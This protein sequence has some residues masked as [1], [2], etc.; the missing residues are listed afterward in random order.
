VLLA[1][2]FLF[3]CGGT[4]HSTVLLINA[5]QLLSGHMDNFLHVT[6]GIII[7]VWH[8]YTTWWIYRIR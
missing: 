4:L 2:A 6:R 7:F 5:V 3:C 1:T 8:D